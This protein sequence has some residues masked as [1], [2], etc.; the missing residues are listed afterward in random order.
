MTEY[1]NKD[2]YNSIKGNC[3]YIDLNGQNIHSVMERLKAEGIMFSAAYGGYR[4]TVTVSKADSQKAFAIAAEYKQAPVQNTQRKQRIIGNIEY[5]KIKD[6][7]FINTDPDTALQVANLLSGDASIRFSGRILENSATIT[8]SGRKNAEMVNRM[9]DNIRNA[10]I[11]NELYKAGYER[12]ADTN[13]FVNIR[14]NASA[15]VVGFRSMDMVREMFGDAS[16]E[17]FHPTA[18]RV[19]SIPEAAEPFYISEVDRVTADERNVYVDENADVPLFDSRENAEQYAEEK[20]IDLT[21][22]EEIIP[23][24][25]VEHIDDTEDLSPSEQLKKRVN[26]ELEAYIAEIKSRPFDEIIEAAYRVTVC[27]QIGEYI[28]NEEPGLTEAQLSALLSMDNVLDEIYLEWVKND[29]VESY[30]DVLMVMQDRADR[31]LLSQQ[32]ENVPVEHFESEVPKDEVAEALSLAENNLTFSVVTINNELVFAVGE[33]IEKDDIHGLEEYQ[34]YIAKNQPDEVRAYVEYCMIGNSELESEMAYSSDID[35]INANLKAVMN[36][37]QTTNLEINN[38]VIVTPD[39]MLESRQA[40]KLLAE[41]KEYITDFLEK[42]YGTEPSE[43]TYKDLENVPLGYTS[44]GDDADHDFSVTANLVDFSISYTLD[45][46]EITTE[47]YDSLEEMT[48][49]ALTCL[50]FDDMV[51]VGNEALEEIE[52]KKFRLVIPEIDVDID[53]RDIDSIA[54]QTP[55][56]VLMFYYS[57]NNK[58]IERAWQSDDNS[59]TAVD[60]DDVAIDIRNAVGNGFAVEVYETAEDRKI[61]EDNSVEIPEN[62]TAID[63]DTAVIMWEQGIT[64]YH[65]GTEIPPMEENGENEHSIFENLS[66]DFYADKEDVKAFRIA[67]DIA[68]E[69]WDMNRVFFNVPNEVGQPYYLSIESGGYDE[70]EDYNKGLNEYQNT[71]K[72]LYTGNFTAVEDYLENVRSSEDVSEEMQEQAAS[73]LDAVKSF[74]NLSGIEDRAK[75]ENE[76]TYKI[77]QLKKGEE[78]HN[79]RFTRWDDMPR[80]NLSFDRKNYDEVYGGNIADVTKFPFKEGI[81]E[82][83][84]K[85]FNSDRPEDFKGRSLSVSDVVVLEDKEGSSAYFVDTVG[86]ADVTDLFFELKKETIDL[87]KLTEVEITEEYD[88]RGDEPDN[89]THVKNTILFTD[90]DK[91]EISRYK[92]FTYDNGVMPDSDEGYTTVTS[93]DML[94]EINGYMDKSR[95]K[96]GISISVTDNVGN[97]KRLNGLLFEFTFGDRN[98]PVEHLEENEKMPLYGKSIEEASELGERDK[99]FANMKENKRCED[100]IVTAIADNYRNSRLDTDGVLSDVLKEFVFERIELVVAARLSNLSFD[101]RIDKSNVEWANDVLSGLSES[102]RKKLCADTHLNSHPGLI[103]LFANKIIDEERVLSQKEQATEKEAEPYEPKLGDKFR[104]NSGEVWE[105]TSL[106]GVMPWYNDQCAITSI[107]GNVSITKNENYSNLLDTAKYHRVADAPEA[108]KTADYS[109]KIGDLVELDGQVYSVADIDSGVISLADT[110]TLLGETMRMTLSEF[111]SSGFEV[112]EANGEETVSADVPVEHLEKSPEKE[113]VPVE[114]HSTN[115]NNFVITDENLGVKTPKARFAANAAAIR[116]LNA[117]EAEHRTATPVEQ[118]I[119][120]GYTGWGAIPNAFDPDNKDWSNEYAELKT[121]LTDEEFIDARRS[122]LNAHFTSPIII[123]AIYEGLANLGFEQGKI[124]EPAMG[125]GNFFGMLPEAM[126]GSELH[127]VELDDITGR[128]A[129]Q[130][131]PD[132]DI[133]IKGFEKTKFENDSFDAVVGNVPFG[134]YKLSDKDY[135]KHKFYIHDYFVAKSIDKVRPGGVVA[136]VTS[137]GTMD[138]ENPEMRMYVA[139]RAEL[140]GA[141]R[142]PN[143]AFKANAGTEVTSDILFFQKRE[144]AIEINPDEIEWL[145]KTETAEGFRVNGY[146]ANHPEMVLGTITEANQKYGPTENTQVIPIEG[147]DLKQQLAEAV[148]NIQGTYTPRA[149]KDTKKKE[150]EDIIPAPANSRVYSYYAVNGSVYFREDGDTMAKANLKGEALKRALAMVELRDTVRELLDMQ[151]D[152]ADRAYDTDISECRAKLNEKYDAFVEQNGH[153]DDKKNIRAFKGD[154][155]YNFLIALES[156][157]KDTGEYEKVDIFY[158]DTVK[159][160]NVVTHVETAEEALILSV[161][162]KARVDFEYMTELCGMSKETLISELEGQIYRLPQEEEKYVTADEYLTGNIRTK[163]R[164]LEFAPEGMDVSKHREALEA[165][166]PKRVEAKDIS[167]KLGAHWVAPEYVTQFVN[168]KFYPSWRSRVEAQYSRA[169]GKWKI[170]GASQSDK[171]SYTA[172]HDYGTKRKNAYAILEGILNHEDMTIKDPKLDEHGEPIR[173]SRDNI[174]KVTNHEETKAVQLMVKKIESEWEDWIFKDPDRREKLVEKYNEVFNSIRHREYDG[175]HLNFVGMN[176][177]ITLKEHQKNAVARALYGGNTLL[178]H[179]VGAGKTFE[180]ITIA[181]EGKRLGLHN[182]S[183]FAVPNSLTEQMGRDFK[184]LYPAANVLVATKKDFEPKNRK[185]LFAKIATGEWDAVI[186]G[187]SQF[188]R[189][190]LS[191]ERMNRYLKAEIESLRSELE[192]A[193]STDGAKSFSVKEIERTITRYEKRLTDEQNKVAKD[194][195]IDFEQMGFDKIFVDECHM[196]KNL[197]TATKMSNVAGIGTT[198]SGKAA[199]LLMKTKYLDELTGGR[200]LVF[201]SGTPVE[202]GYLRSKMPILRCCI[203]KNDYHIL[204]V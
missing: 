197:G 58:T 130:H 70:W 84:F 74:R 172:I 120:S 78:Y 92:D 24:V 76:P 87:S 64:V 142:L 11:I 183:L 93:Q 48:E 146:F 108:V 47:K 44:L 86:M 187:H 79:L 90:L 168:Q 62:L 194:D 5:S 106:T 163:L 171:G 123:N 126:R 150:T 203:A 143:N 32:R 33:Y 102:E 59:D 138:K 173:D 153:F 170:E 21:G 80:F 134:D 198:G 165:A 177:D 75:K 189:M 181:M 77:Y 37:P 28:T 57:S 144:R 111:L 23:D 12:L 6:R 95:K 116:T 114:H 202:T 101:G 190:G 137:K 191:A 131:Y 89:S 179:C 34:D 46:V 164:Q 22:F 148:Q 3:S 100:A 55:D 124:L 43:D 13:G 66:D 9:I 149:E 36:H 175:S 71:L 1:V 26:A 201:A 42:E 54:V 141:I 196:Y 50:D 152:N 94:D 127:G 60:I 51:T 169:S 103:N 91:F 192:E 186:V 105:L 38:Y 129:R 83:I 88:R 128:I 15:E 117:I 41:A 158:H 145:N 35:F 140:L 69:I 16:N 161:A 19:D 14:N 27:K 81:L 132:A 18:Y 167:V 25:P 135:D 113:N 147:A 199:E 20:G 136:V 52:N 97:T 73:L 7:N 156:K 53:M 2:Y 45:G 99:Y 30:D 193:K 10:D 17:F 68:S 151:L 98:V 180:M 122:T 139:Q 61:A 63:D 174:V 162:E 133:L 85:K 182:K 107:S 188:D 195:Y 176:S 121:L 204:A 159:P 4:N 8:V 155:G 184:K 49:V 72:A 110:E 82:D 160:N 31:I 39:E 185:M 29:S 200:G 166:M 119:L 56:D 118:A 40:D 125:I 109:P 104:D 65:S 115:A 96:S 67:D 178:A 154:D 112:V 157:N